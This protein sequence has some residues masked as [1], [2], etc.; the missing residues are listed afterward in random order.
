MPGVIV[1]SRCF[2]YLIV[3]ATL[4][5][6][7]LLFG[8]EVEQQEFL[9]KATPSLTAA[10]QLQPEVDEA[11]LTLKHGHQQ[12]SLDATAPSCPAR[13]QQA[14][15]LKQNTYFATPTNEAV[16]LY[17]V[18]APGAGWLGMFFPVSIQPHAP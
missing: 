16:P 1:H 17:A 5:W 4:L 14:E 18:R 11:E 15:A 6:A 9:P 2:R 8:Q 12:V 13:L 10:V 3:P 7:F